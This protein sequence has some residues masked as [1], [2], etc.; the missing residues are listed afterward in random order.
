MFVSDS[1]GLTLPPPI[2]T[3]FLSTFSAIKWHHLNCQKMLRGIVWYTTKNIAY[4]FP[5]NIEE[6]LVR[7]T[8]KVNPRKNAF[9]KTLPK[10]HK[11]SHTSNLRIW[12]WVV[13]G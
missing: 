6:L 3:F 8:T 7:N 11:T 1:I 10:S 2:I 4:L 13:E 9:L 5:H 12:G